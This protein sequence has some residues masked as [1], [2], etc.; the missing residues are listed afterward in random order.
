MITVFDKHLTLRTGQC[1]VRHWVPDLLPLVEDPAD[2]LGTQ[3]LVTHR[4]PLE[5][6]PRRYDVFRRKADGCVKV[7]LTPQ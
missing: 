1:N 3:D 2:P 7:V 5:E 4:V 6:A